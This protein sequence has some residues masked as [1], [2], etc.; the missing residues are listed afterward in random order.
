MRWIPGV[1]LCGLIL[2]PAGAAAE[3]AQ[4]LALE[5][6]EV[7]Q[8]H[9]AD[10][11]GLDIGAAADSIAIVGP[12]WAKLD[13]ALTETRKV[14]LLYWRGVLAQCLDKE[15]MAIRDLEGFVAARASDPSYQGQVKDASRR[16]RI[17]RRRNS[18]G[19][20]GSEAGPFVLG[21][22]LLGI[23]G[24]FGALSGWQAATADSKYVAYHS[25]DYTRGSFPELY[26][27]GEEA[28]IAANAFIGAAVGSGT[29]GLVSLIVGAAAAGRMRTAQLGPMLPHPALSFLPAGERSVVGL[30]INGRW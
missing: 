24:L 12:V 26:R 25:G 21:G 19:G 7:L 16:L 22:T 30:S 4:A 5:A 9:C 28:T 17:L 6:S 29:A 20:Q 15:E 13:A 1:V 23:G 14:Y 8:A 18:G 3:D 10:A 11:G 27:E 2:M